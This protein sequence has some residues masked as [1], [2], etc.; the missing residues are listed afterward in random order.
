MAGVS[1]TA[2]AIQNIRE[3][4]VDLQKDM[5]KIGTLVDRLDMAI[6]KLTEFSDNVSKLIA[7]HE[8]RITY[9]ESQADSLLQEIKNLRKES[10]DQHTALAKRIDAMEKWMWMVVGGSIVVGFVINVLIKIFVH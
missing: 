7:I 5:A 1:G 6:D 3:D 10:T 8:T 2:V 9:H 4:I